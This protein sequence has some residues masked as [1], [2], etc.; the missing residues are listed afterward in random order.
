MSDHVVVAWREKRGGTWVPEDRLRASL[1]GAA[2]LVPVS[3]LLSGITTQYVEGTVG[4]VINL[5]CLFVNGLGVGYES[6]GRNFHLN[7]LLG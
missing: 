4:L 2:V 5:V 3:A 7:F 1:W 6:L